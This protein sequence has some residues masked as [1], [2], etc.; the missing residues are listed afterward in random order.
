MVDRPQDLLPA[1][2]DR[3]NARDADGFAALFHEYGVIIG[4]DGSTEL[5]ASNIAEHLAAIFA[6][7]TPAHFVGR[8]DAV[9]EINA[10]LAVVRG[11]AGMVAPDG[12]DFVPDRNVIQSI[13]A[14]Q[15]GGRWQVRLFQN[16]PAR[17]DGRPEAVEEM[18]AALAALR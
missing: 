3:W 2:H 9:T 10:D 4:F 5:G 17:F 8:V 16:T 15:A 18:T 6:D 12:G 11:I 1:L 7:H 13:V 14:A